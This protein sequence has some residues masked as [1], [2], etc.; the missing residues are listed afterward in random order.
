MFNKNISKKD[1]L[2]Q[3]CRNCTKS[4]AREGYLN[5]PNRKKDVRKQALIARD[6]SKE[7]IAKEKNKGC[8]VCDEKEHCC[9][10]FHH[11]NPSEKDYNVA[12]MIGLSLTSL[13]KEINK[14][15]VLCS[16]CHKKVHAKLITLRD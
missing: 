2:Q 11:L 16:N 8:S 1:G 4:Y 5:N 10:E 12:S 6:K 14:C 9:L 3:Y 15:V 13:A 7:L